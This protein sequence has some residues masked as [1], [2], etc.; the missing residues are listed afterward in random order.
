MAPRKPSTANKEKV[1][2]QGP[3]PDPLAAI[4][5]A[6]EIFNED[7]HKLKLPGKI[8][9]ISG[10]LGR[11]PKNGYNKFNDY[12]YVL[13]SDLVEQIRYYLA[14]ARILIYP[15]RFI[16][17]AVHTFEGFTT[18]SGKMRD[19]LT[20]NVIEYE[21][22]DGTTGES[23]TFEVNGQGSDPRDKGSNKAS[24]S[25]MKFGYLRLFNISSG[26][27][28]EEDTRG[29]QRAS[30]DLPSGPPKVSDAKATDA[31]RGGKQANATAT[32]IRAISNLSNK[33]ELGATGL[34]GVIER[35]LGDKLELPDNDERKQGEALSKY[36]LGQTGENAGKLIY[37]L[38]E[39]EKA[40]SSEE[41]GNG[42]G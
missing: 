34:A 9:V 40:V 21:V 19:I 8:A 31:Q 16:S 13:E 25:A 30:E 36:L 29:D 32:Q 14:A 18:S 20:D 3:A 33:L 22:V 26:E 41:P 37:A 7:F 35:V 5:A 27:D 12:W 6:L 39:M 11:V 1:E 4:T 23:F 38:Q 24:T 28:A 2:Q 10:H 17:H 15:K 42:Y